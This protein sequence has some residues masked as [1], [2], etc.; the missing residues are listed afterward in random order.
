MTLTPEELERITVLTRERPE[1]AV[2]TRP[3]GAFELQVRNT[4][5]PFKADRRLCAAQRLI[6]T[7]DSAVVDDLWA[8]PM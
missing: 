1:L 7:G 2:K 6:G 5:R 3:A 8:V 4:L